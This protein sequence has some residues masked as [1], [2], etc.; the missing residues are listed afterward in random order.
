MC[1]KLG[2]PAITKIEPG[3]DGKKFDVNIIED[4]CV[5]CDL[6]LQVCKFDALGRVE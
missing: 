1:L 6:C 2:C 4:L 5:G 3:T